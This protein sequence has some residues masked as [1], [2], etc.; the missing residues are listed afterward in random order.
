MG[1]MFA[2][3]AGRAAGARKMRPIGA[4]LFDSGS[5]I[6]FLS[7]SA[8]KE[9]GLRCDTSE[10][11]EHI[12]GAP[13]AVCYRDVE[14]H[15]TGT[16]CFA[17]LR[18]AVPVDAEQDVPTLLG[19]DFLQRSG[20]FLDFGRGQHRIGCDVN[21]RDPNPPETVAAQKVRFK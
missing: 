17:A 16:D 3:V 14:L 8:A 18:V 10:G 19:A 9:A 15:V 4:A 13:T 7:R 11:T 2:S 20:G 1:R 5:V 6:S 12:G 21:A